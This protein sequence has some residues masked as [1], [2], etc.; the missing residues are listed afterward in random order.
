MSD[1][2][3]FKL[4]VTAAGAALVWY[5]AHKLVNGISNAGSSV[6]N[7]VEGAVSDAAS[8]VGN[9]AGE[10]YQFVSNL[11]AMSWQAMSVVPGGSLAADV[12]NAPTSTLGSLGFAAAPP[13]SSLLDTLKAGPLGGLWGMLSG[14]GNS[15]IFGPAPSA[16][17]DFGTGPNNWGG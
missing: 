5:A 6:I 3:E 8:A 4:I 9:V 2:L 7:G 12:V 10:G 16:G 11:P 13:G 15:N 1:D 17:L 14:D